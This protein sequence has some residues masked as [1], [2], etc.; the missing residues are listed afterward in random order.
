MKITG[1][2]LIYP[3]SA[4]SGSAG[5]TLN[6]SFGDSPEDLAEFLTGLG[7]S[8]NAQA[9]ALAETEARINAGTL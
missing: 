9:Q 4:P 3:A 6:E 5:I 8:I 7:D 1:E 2:L